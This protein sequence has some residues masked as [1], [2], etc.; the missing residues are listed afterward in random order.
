MARVN[1]NNAYLAADGLDIS[2]DWTGDIKPSGSANMVKVTAGSGTDHEQYAAGLDDGTFDLSFIVDDT[3]FETVKHIF[4]RGKKILLEYGPRGQVSG[5]PVYECYVLVRDIEGETMN[6]DKDKHMF[7]L[8]F[9]EAD[10][11]IRELYTDTYA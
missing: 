3:R 9:Q 1:T 8:K 6:I 11:P 5:M 7:N 10:A 2:P 4:Q